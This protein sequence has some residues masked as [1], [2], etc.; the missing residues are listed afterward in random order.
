MVFMGIP[1]RCPLKWLRSLQ[2]FEETGISHSEF[3]HRQ[4]AEEGGG[5]LGGPLKF[6]NLCILWLHADQTGKSPLM[7]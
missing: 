7:P 1:P 3:L 2:V 4:H 6:P 5:P